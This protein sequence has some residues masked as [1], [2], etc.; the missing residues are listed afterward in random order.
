MMTT[1]TSK[2]FEQ[3]LRTLRERL[4]A[5]GG[6][7]EQQIRRAMQALTDRDTEIAREVIAADEAMAAVGDVGMWR[8]MVEAA[9]A[10]RVD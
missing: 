4:C 8:N 1:H 9:I 5:M 2:D 7:C 6:R 10:E 3:E